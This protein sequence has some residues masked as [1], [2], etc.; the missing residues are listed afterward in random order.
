MSGVVDT[1]LLLYAVNLDA[2]EHERARDF[3]GK[4][5]QS[6]SRWYLTEGIVYEFLRVSTH[7]RVFA[8]PLSAT[9]GMSFVCALLDNSRFGLLKAGARHWEMLR[10]VVTG[11]PH[12]SGN[13]F[14]DIRT[15]A[16]M[17]E[18]GVRRIYTA[19]ADFLRFTGIEV[20]DP[21]KPR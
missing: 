13:L 16:L 17:H 15:V 2:G 9:E 5:G 3:L 12:P 1:N 21:V 8:K 19:D 10:Q 7:A 4:A 6:E 14:F 18:H 20:I 11:M